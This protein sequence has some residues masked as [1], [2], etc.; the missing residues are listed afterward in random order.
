MW[1]GPFVYNFVYIIIIH[2]DLLLERDTLAYACMFTFWYPNVEKKLQS[3]QF[4]FT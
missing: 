2:I 4:F 1:A 3:F